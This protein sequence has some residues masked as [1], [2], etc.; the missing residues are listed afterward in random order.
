ML[1]LPL[2]YKIKG[3]LQKTCKIL[4]SDFSS[5]K[6]L[7]ETYLSYR[8]IG[9]P[10]LTEL[11][12]YIP[13]DAIQVCGKKMGIVKGKTLLVNNE[14]ELIVLYNYCLFHYYIGDKNAIDR[15]MTINRD[16]LVSDKKTVALAMK[17][18]QF[19]I[20]SIERTLPHGGV[21]VA[22]VLRGGKRE[23]L[24]DKGF[25]ESGIPGLLLASTILRYPEF[26]TT[27]GTALPLNNILNRIEL[28]LGD[29]AKK[30]ES[31]DVLPK[32]QQSKFIANLLKIC[33]REEVSENIRYQDIL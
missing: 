3:A 29:Y 33:F 12:K 10:L 27:T 31:F 6:Q 14:D 23:L 7:L 19:A 15:Y 11:L 5:S 8:A 30:Y 24:I 25:S 26:I 9:Q 17:N 28:L 22:D 1:I 16:S 32:I 13:K 20:F 18:A 21:I 4:D 2:L